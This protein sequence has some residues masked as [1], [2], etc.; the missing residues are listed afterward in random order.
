MDQPAA[1][2]SPSETGNL[3]PYLIG[4]VEAYATVGE[5]S[6]VLREVWGE[7]REPVVV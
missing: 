5:M 4:A 7:F 2:K 6:G 1:V 3:M